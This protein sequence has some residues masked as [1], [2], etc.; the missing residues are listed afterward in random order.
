MLC[1]PARTCRRALTPA[2]CPLCA[3]ELA[4]AGPPAMAPVGCAAGR[5]LRARSHARM[6]ACMRALPT[7]QCRVC[8]RVRVQVHYIMDEMLLNG[9]IVDTNKA[10][11]LEPVQLLEQ[12]NA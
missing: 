8:V 7:E 2:P 1:F 9:C 12:V 11:V 6:R 5:R 4:S 3:L 10:N